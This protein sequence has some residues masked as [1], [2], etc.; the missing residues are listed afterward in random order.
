MGVGASMAYAPSNR[1]W[2]LKTLSRATIAIGAF[3][4]FAPAGSVFAADLPIPTKSPQPAP[5]SRFWLEGDYLIWT[6]TGDKLPALATTSPPGTPLALAGVLG[7]PGTTVLFGNSAVND[8]WR[9]GGR[10]QG[11]YWIDPGHTVGV[12]G[13]FFG[14]ADASSGFSATLNGSSILARPFVNA[15]TGVQS[16]QLV[17]FPGLTAGTLSANDTSRLLGAGVYFRQDI[18]S[19]GAEHFS[20]LVG[21]RYLRSTDALQITSNQTSPLFVGT[22]TVN[23]SFNAASNFNGLDLGVIGEARAGRWLLEWKASVALG[24]NF[25]NAQINGATSFGGVT[26]SGGLLALSSNIGT[27]S[28]T[29]FGVVPALALKAGYQITENWRLVAGYDLLYWTGVLR[30]G[31]LVDTT[32]NVNLI[33]PATGGGPLRPQAAFN[34]SALLAQGFNLGVRADF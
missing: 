16:S 9:S 21:Y 29:T 19:W 10:V 12:E 20:A 4:L 33:P 3:I 27:F 15:L 26:T 23:D 14:L 6:V 24:A 32:I 1:L 5:V 30:G 7:A 22:L 28:Q 25:N 17:A 31:N 11:G 18:G 34:T 2:R 13:Y 8:G